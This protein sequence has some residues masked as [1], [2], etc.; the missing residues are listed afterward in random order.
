MIDTLQTV[1]AALSL[2]RS[3]LPA[4][5][6]I[7]SRRL[8]FSSFPII[9]YSLTSGTR[10]ADGSVGAR[11]IR[12]QAEAQQ[13]FRSRER[14]GPGR[15]ASGVPRRGRSGTDAA[16]EDVDCRH[17]RRHQQDQHHRLARTSQ[18]Q[19]P[20][21]SRARDRAGAQPRGHRRGRHQA[22]EQRPGSRAGRRRRDAGGRARVYGGHRERQARGPAEH[23]PSAG[24]QHGAGGRRSPRGSRR[25]QAD[26]FR[27]GSS[28]ICS[29]TSP[30]SSW[31]RSAAFATRSSSASSWRLSSSGSSSATGARR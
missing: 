16:R 24:Q 14:P 15:A 29:T 17:P 30:T 26:R 22:R 1:D 3:S 9:G 13:P 12:H 7:Q 21:L 23:Q 20:A 19:S 27:P 31:R 4:T 2:A 6:Q 5:A 25:H 18:P 28:S 8:D 11:D 10:A